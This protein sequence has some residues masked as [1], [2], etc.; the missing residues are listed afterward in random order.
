MELFSEYFK[1][2][3]ILSRID[4][5]VKLLVALT[6]LI[7]VLSYKGFVLPALVTLFCLFL[8]ITMKV[9]LRVFM[10]RFSEPVFIASIILFLKLFFSGK[11]VLFS[12]SLPASHFSLF[13]LTGY[14]DG[15]MD[16]LMIAIRI[17]GAVSIVAVMGLS[18]PFTEFIAGLS[19]LRVPKGFIEVLMFAYRYIFVLF[20]D[21]MVIYNAQKNRLGYSNI[22]RGL[23][24][25]S[26]LTGSLILKAFEHSH[27]ITTA[28]IQRGYDGN[29]PMLKHKPFKLSEVV[30]SVLFITVMG[31]VWKI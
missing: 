8:C 19:W 29:M 18:T 3:H 26:A 31:F 4:A 9:P 2:D 28:M 30:V 21:A 10:L 5:R 6:I 27:N 1:K 20:E 7:M 15:L 25:F 23:G 24:S 12:I 17:L 13:T 16:G 11:D 14:K 22:R